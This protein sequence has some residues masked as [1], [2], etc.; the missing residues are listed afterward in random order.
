MLPIAIEAPAR[1]GQVRLFR[2]DDIPDVME[3]RLGWRVAAKLMRRWFNDISYTLPMSAKNGK[4][5][6]R[7]LAPSIID[8]TAVTMGWALRFARVRSGY[9]KL[10]NG[11]RTPAGLALLRRRLHSLKPVVIPLSQSGWRLGDLSRP[12]KVL[13]ET[14]QVNYIAVG[15]LTDPLDDFYGAI[16]VGLLKIAVSGLVTPLA[17]QRR[18]IVIDEVGIYLRDTY[19]FN[20]DSLWLSQPLGYWGFQGVERGFGFRWDVEVKTRYSDPDPA[21]E[22]RKYEVQNDDF[23]RWRRRYGRGGDFVIYSDVRRERLPRP[24][25]LEV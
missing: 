7:T 15:S 17:G 8:E 5:D 22:Q 19:D 23:R 20:D 1:P 10:L 2:L 4:V 25:V 16:G 14:C 11:W 21:L 12:G 24:L 13:D 3:R 9:Q 6:S 18:R